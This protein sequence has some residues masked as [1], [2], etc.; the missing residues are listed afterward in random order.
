[1]CFSQIDQT[2]AETQDTADLSPASPEAERLSL[3]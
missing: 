2:V 3:Y 1:M